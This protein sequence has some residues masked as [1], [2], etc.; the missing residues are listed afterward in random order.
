MTK[1][2]SLSVPQWEALLKKLKVDYSSEPPSTLLIRNQMK[3][4]LGFVPRHHEY[5]QDAGDNQFA[6][7]RHI[8]F[9][10]FYDEQKKTMF[11]LKYSDFIRS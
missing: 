4:K 6:Q 5:W 1:S 8:V 11:L 9:L 3:K 7:F 2:I 10:D